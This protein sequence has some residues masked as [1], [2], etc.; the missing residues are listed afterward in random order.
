METKPGWKSTE[1]LV[2]LMVAV[3]SVMVAA[4]VFGPETD[5]EAIGSATA[6]IVEAIAGAVSMLAAAWAAG[7]YS[8][9]RTDAK[10]N[11]GGAP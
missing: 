11:G 8:K 2:T 4:G 3:G 9:A 10:V 6:T 1:F 7:S 5:P